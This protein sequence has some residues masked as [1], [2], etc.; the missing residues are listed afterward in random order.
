MKRKEIIL[1]GL[2]WLL[3]GCTHKTNDIDIYQR[4]IGYVMPLVDSG[5]IVDKYIHVYEHLEN[6]SS[7]LYSFLDGNSARSEVGEYPPKMECLSKHLMI[8]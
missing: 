7:T 4:A 5:C 8:F 2:L 6:D 3:I 1:F